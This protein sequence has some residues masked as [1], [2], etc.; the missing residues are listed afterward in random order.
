MTLTA[1]QY[2]LNGLFGPWLF[3]CLAMAAAEAGLA[4]LRWVRS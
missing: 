4:V 1:S 3:A 2:A